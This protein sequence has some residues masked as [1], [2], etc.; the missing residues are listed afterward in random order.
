MGIFGTGSLGTVMGALLTKKGHDIDLIDINADH[1][2]AL[3]SKGARITGLMHLVQPVKAI[4]CTEMT[5]RY[6][7]LFY[8][9]KTTHN[10]SALPYVI[11]HLKKDGVLVCCQNGLP[12][13]AVAEVVGDDRVMG[14]VVGWGATYLKPG[15]SKLTS[16]PLSMSY[17]IG[18]LDGSDSSRLEQIYH[19]LKDCGQPVK[20][21]NLL[22]IRWTKLT[23]NSTFST[24]SA[25]VAG[26]YGDVLDDD[27]ALTCGIHIWREA[28]A[29]AR[30]AAIIPETIQGADIRYLDVNSPKELENMMP[31]FRMMM[32]PHRGIKTGMLYDIEAGHMP[33]IETYN[34]II[35]KWGEKYG[36]DTPVNRQVVDIVKG[37]WKGDYKIEAA[38]LKRITLP[39][40]S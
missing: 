10:D 34:G 2:A 20:T 27:K 33:E 19:I 13:D 17:D 12:E 4:R 21:H 28:L 39:T 38:N 26:P 24:M 9:T 22:G 40:L 29:V 32:E 11:Q 37:M 5:D 23:V 15:V 3:N 8:L 16:A 36:V 1:V 18:E 6:D 25:V 31:V 35:C 14:C 7:I 30:A